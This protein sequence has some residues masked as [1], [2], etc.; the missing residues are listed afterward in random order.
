MVSHSSEKPDPVLMGINDALEIRYPHDNPYIKG[1][2]IEIRIPKIIASYRD[3]EVFYLFEN[4]ATA[5]GG[6]QYD[7]EGNR[8]YKDLIPSRLSYVLRIPFEG[9]SFSESSP[10]AVTLPINLDRQAENLVLRTQLAMKGVPDSFFDA[11]FE[12]VIQPVIADLGT[13][14]LNLVYPEGTDLT[15]FPLPLCYIDGNLTDSSEPIL[16]GTGVHHLSVVSEQYR[17]EMR[18]FSIEKAAGT[19]LEIVLQPVTTDIT[20]QAPS[21]TSI[22]LDGVPVESHRVIP[23]E[24]G[25]HLISYRLADYE[26]TK[27]VTVVRGKSYTVSLS[28]DVNIFEQE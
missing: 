10:Y 14:T 25:D 24:A 6:D 3:S 7:Y 16:L 11:Q 21:G 13:I 28:V 22:T 2:E 18:T 9:E 27:T 15:E 8:L 12:I 26:I 20:I 1:I 19:E 17:N 5:E 23:V 4:V